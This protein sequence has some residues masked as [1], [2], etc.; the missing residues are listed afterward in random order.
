MIKNNGY[1][2]KA[3]KEGLRPEERLTV[4]EWADKYRYL[5]QKE[6]A[7]P[8]KWRTD[9]APYLKE[10][11]DCLSS[12]SLVE[13]V[14]WMAGAQLG[15]TS[16]GLCWIGYVIDHAPGPMMA[17][18]P[19]VDLAKRFSKQRVDPLIQESEK[20]KY[21][22]K[23][24]KEKDS[25]N[26]IL[27]KDFRGGMLI[28]T[29]ANS[30]VGLRSM[31]ARYLMADEVDGWPGDVDGEGDP[32]DLAIARTR[33]FSKRKILITSTPTI[34]GQSRIETAF[35]EGDQRFYHIPCPHCGEYQKLEWKNIKYTDNDPN[36]A[37]YI[38]VVNGCTIQEHYKT[39][40]LAKGR[41]IPENPKA[42]PKIRSYHINSLY[43]P[44]GW[45]SWKEIVKEFIACK[46]EPNRLRTFVNTILGETWKERGEAPDWRR[47]YERREL[48][49]IGIVPSGVKFLTAGVDVQKD[50]L[51][52]Q[53]VGWGKQKESW[54]IDHI[55]IPGDTSDLSQAG[56]WNQLSAIFNQEWTTEDNTLM[57]LRLVA[58]D[59]GYNTQTVYNFCRKFP[60]S[61]V[62]ATKGFDNLQLTVGAPSSVDINY[63]GKTIN[64]GMKLWP[65]GSSHI[66]SEIYGLLKLNKPTEGELEQY[67]YPPGFIHFPQYDEEYFRQLT[68]EEL[69]AKVIKGYR[70]FY[71]TKV[72]ERNETL[73]TLVMARAAA[74]IAG[75][76][77]LNDQQLDHVASVSSPINEKSK[78]NPVN[79]G[80]NN[81]IIRKKSNFW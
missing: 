75:L 71:W 76:D 81:K 44:L 6:S 58:I 64:R 34:T 72:Y 11:I 19:T 37:V 80:R 1:Y 39:K 24:A 65:I 17:V 40:F 66:K 47:I 25:G 27:S 67:G 55:V 49:N 56:P 3:F 53:V 13:K 61:K 54:S 5:S 79:S 77:R 21:K 22:V 48:Y 45:L 15:K 35:F 26:T 14:A 38:C 74:S 43:S 69:V 50:R 32:L 4:S 73:D 63:Q 70:R 8:G 12:T 9:R 7:E 20:L 10:V 59:S 68:A 57:P 78:N 31:P 51:E 28:M 30:A 16:G 60:I 36:T 42:D 29:G 18:Q 33:T 52:M 23:S 46:K 62:V 2:S 41:W